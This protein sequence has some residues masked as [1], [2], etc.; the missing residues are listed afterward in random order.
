MH[1]L[2][3]ARDS[4]HGGTDGVLACYISFCPVHQIPV[5]SNIQKHLLMFLYLQWFG[6]AQYTKIT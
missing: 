3:V 6:L 4:L 2:L 5:L 1:N